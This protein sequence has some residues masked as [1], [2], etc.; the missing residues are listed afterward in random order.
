MKTLIAILAFAG[1]IFLSA[2]QP[3]TAQSGCKYIVNKAVLTAAQWQYCFQ[4]KQDVGANA[5]SGTW[6]PTS[7]LTLGHITSATWQ[8]VGIQICVAATFVMPTVTNSASALVQGLPFPATQA[9]QI[10]AAS[11]GLYAAITA[12][13]FTFIGATG[14]N[15]AWAT[16]TY[17]QMSGLTETLNFCYS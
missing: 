6:V 4:Q 17:T 13:Q 1:A 2:Q 9:G 16:K 15:P 10:G 11:G 12:S 7:P 5:T 8:K 14:S 3:A